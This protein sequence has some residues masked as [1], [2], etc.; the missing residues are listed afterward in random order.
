MRYP[1][2][3]ILLLFAITAHAQTDSVRTEYQTEDDKISK[4]EVKRFIRYITRANVEE[5]TLIKLG[6]WPNTRLLA[7]SSKMGFGVGLDTD[8]SIER[9]VSP[10]FSVLFGV[11]NSVDYSS[12]KLDRTTTFNPPYKTEIQSLVASI[13]AKT[14]IRYYYGLA[15]RIRQGKSANN[16]SGF[17][18]AAQAERPILFYSNYRQYDPINGENRSSSNT[19]LSKLN[20]PSFAFQWGIQQRL[21]RRGYTDVN[22]GPEITTYGRNYIYRSMLGASSYSFRIN[23][24]VGLGW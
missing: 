19:P 20:Q 3:A 16:L 17:Y 5:K 24:I 13:N 1:F 7:Q 12:N 4:A 14:A 8:L 11:E 23:V 10:S 6:F 9:K 18:L 15:R 21:G 2:A 22:I